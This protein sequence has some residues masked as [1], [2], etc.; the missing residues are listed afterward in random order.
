MLSGSVR[1]RTRVCVRRRE[2]ARYLTKAVFKSPPPPAFEAAK[3]GASFAKP[4]YVASKQTQFY[5]IKNRARSKIRER[6][7]TRI[8]WYQGA[9][10]HTHT[11]THTHTGLHK[12]RKAKRLFSV[13]LLDEQQRK[14]KNIIYFLESA[15]LQNRLL[16]KPCW[17]QEISNRPTNASVHSEQ[18]HQ[19]PSI[20]L[21][22]LFNLTTLSFKN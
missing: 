11:H 21:S 15:L 18:N 12:A 1:K 17:Q 20:L 13:N 16:K 22:A 2:C 9:R 8:N 5:F 10:A 7:K 14:E 6:K 3:R 4:S 19:V